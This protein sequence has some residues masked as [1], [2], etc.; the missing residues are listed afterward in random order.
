MDPVIHFE[1]PATLQA[2]SRGVT[3]G[4]CVLTGE[5]AG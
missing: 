1:M 3:G 5:Q 2:H 4:T